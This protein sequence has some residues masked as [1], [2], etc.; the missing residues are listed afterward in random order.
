MS[1]FERYTYTPLSPPSVTISQHHVLSERATPVR[2]YSSTSTHSQRCESYSVEE[3]RLRVYDQGRSISCPVELSTGRM[4]E[5]GG[6]SGRYNSEEDIRQRGWGSRGSRSVDMSLYDTEQPHYGG[7]Q[8]QDTD[9]LEFEKRAGVVQHGYGDSFV[10]GD[11]SATLYEDER[12]PDPGPQM[13]PSVV[14]EYGNVQRGKDKLNKRRTEE[15]E[16]DVM[17]TPTRWNRHRD[18]STEKKAGGSR[19]GYG[20]AAQEEG[21]ITSPRPPGAYRMRPPNT[22]M[23]EQHLSGRSSSQRSPRPQTSTTKTPLSLLPPILVAYTFLHTLPL[24]RS[25]PSHLNALIG[26]A[27]THIVTFLTSTLFILLLEKFRAD[28]YTPLKSPVIVVLFSPYLVFGMV[29]IICGY[30]RL[31]TTVPIGGMLVWVGLVWLCAVCFVV[32]VV[33]IGVLS[34][35]VSG[36]VVGDVKDLKE[37]GPEGGRMGLKVVNGCASADGSE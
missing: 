29:K 8:P 2:S 3:D 4:G 35:D 28:W 24:L 7:Q 36:R 32:G 31:L 9:P 20:R 11:S 34:W 1:T 27:P 10:L 25:W 16:S 12:G 19:R 37:K 30:L 6:L 26:R 17:M 18:F 23:Y 15:M 14:W 21:P 22:S 33:G 5:F 13:V